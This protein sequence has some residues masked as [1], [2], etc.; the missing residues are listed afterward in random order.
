MEERGI[1]DK[2]KSEKEDKIGKDCD[3]EN[4]YRGAKK[5][6]VSEGKSL[7]LEIYR[8]QSKRLISDAFS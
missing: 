2:S 6:K 7:A 1:W 8:Q 4:T 3:L 5:P